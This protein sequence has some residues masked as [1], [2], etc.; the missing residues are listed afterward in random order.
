MFGYTEARDFLLDVHRHGMESI[1]MDDLPP[2]NDETEL[3]RRS[4]SHRLKRRAATFAAR[5]A[6][7]SWLLLAAMP[8]V[9]LAC[10]L[11]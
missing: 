5:C 10:A 7:G 8:L 1:L 11:N 3:S 2:R 9:V 6:M 4:G